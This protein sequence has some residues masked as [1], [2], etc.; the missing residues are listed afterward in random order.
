MPNSFLQSEGLRLL[1]GGVSPGEVAA[2]LGV[3]RSTV[4]RWRDQR[5]ASDDEVLLAAHPKVLRKLVSL[6]Q[7]GDIRAI[8]E[9]LSRSSE[10]VPASVAPLPFGLDEDTFI[11]VLE[12]ELH[13]VTPLLASQWLA[14]YFRINERL[15]KIASGELPVPPPVERTTL[16]PPDPTYFTREGSPPPTDLPQGPISIGGD[17]EEIRGTIGQERPERL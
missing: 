15:E 7:K 3:S 12:H 4:Y 9:V 2:Q 10:V 13:R 5:L 16:P 14:I 6:A 11:R 1:E 8:K 17:H